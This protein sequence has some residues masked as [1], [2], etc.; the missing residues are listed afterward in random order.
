MWNRGV[1]Q[2]LV[3][4][5]W[6]KNRDCVSLFLVLGWTLRFSDIFRLLKKLQDSIRCVANLDEDTQQVTSSS[7]TAS[8]LCFSIVLADL[9]GLITLRNVRIVIFLISSSISIR[10]GTL[11]RPKRPRHLAPLPNVYHCHSS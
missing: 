8:I 5:L 4:L 6:L 1:F 3:G 11:R 2:G 7:R 9:K 10:F